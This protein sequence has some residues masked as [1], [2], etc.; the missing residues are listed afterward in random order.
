MIERDP[1]RSNITVDAATL[2]PKLG[3]T[4]AAL[5]EN[6]ANGLVTG[7]VETGVGEDQGRTRLTFRYRTRIWRVVIEPDGALREEPVP[8]RRKMKMP[9]LLDLAQM[10]RDGS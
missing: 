9:N 6:M 3:L 2:A 7:V 10:A 1:D 8:A 5:R 4:A